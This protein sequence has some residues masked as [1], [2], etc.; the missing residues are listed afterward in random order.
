MEI[1]TLQTLIGQGK[2]TN[3][4]ANILNCSQTNIRY[5]LRKFGLNTIYISKNKTC[6]VCNA[7]LQG[8]QWDYC[9]KQCKGIKYSS[10]P[11]NYIIQQERAHERKK[12]LVDQKGGKCERCGYARNYASL[13]FHHKNPSDKVFNIDV[14]KISNTN[15][16]S[17]ITE[18]AKCL[19]LCHNCHMEIHYPLLQI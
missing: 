12:F 8:R 13:C 16:K 1:D 7:A 17:L 18:A 3:E 10:N 4:I 19:L 5:W 11:N 2:S 9:S 6:K 14:R 15:M